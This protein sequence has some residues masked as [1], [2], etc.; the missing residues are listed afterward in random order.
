MDPKKREWDIRF[1]RNL[2]VATLGLMVLFFLLALLNYYLQGQ[3]KEIVM[4][5]GSFFSLSMLALLMNFA[6]MRMFDRNFLRAYAEFFNSQR[7]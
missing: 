4:L 7:R 1:H 2:K 5:V 6:S 3:L